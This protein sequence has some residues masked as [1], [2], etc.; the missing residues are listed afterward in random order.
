M[1]V[2][3][4]NT[5]LKAEKSLNIHNNNYLFDFLIKIMFLSVN[6]IFQRIFFIKKVFL[7][8]GHCAHMLF[9]VIFSQ[10][11]LIFIFILIQE[12]G[13]GRLILLLEKTFFSRKSP[14]WCPGGIIT[15]YNI[16]SR[17]IYAENVKNQNNIFLNFDIWLRQS[18]HTYL[19]PKFNTC[20]E[21][22]DV[23]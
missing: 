12:P 5:F 1:Q 11:M 16:I 18:A 23:G 14:K 2:F 9:Y 4:K 22:E 7:A 8:P 20:P 21:E 13:F 3:F 6:V 10:K 15:T 17:F 19:Q